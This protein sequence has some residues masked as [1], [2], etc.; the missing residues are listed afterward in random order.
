MGKVATRRS[1][2]IKYSEYE[3]SGEEEDGSPIVKR[4]RKSSVSSDVEK[5]S[6]VGRKK[7]DD[8]RWFDEETKKNNKGM[9]Q[10]KECFVS[11]FKYSVD[12]ITKPQIP[13]SGRKG[14]CKKEVLVATRK[15]PRKLTQ[16]NSIITTSSSGSLEGEE[17][18]K[19][20]VCDGCGEVVPDCSWLTAHIVVCP[21]MN[22][23]L[24]GGEDNDLISQ[25]SIQ[26][27][28]PIEENKKNDVKLEEKFDETSIEAEN[29]FTAQQQQQL[30]EEQLQQQQ[31]QQQQIQ[32]HHIATMN[33][34]EELKSVILGQQINSTNPTI[35]ISNATSVIIQ[36]P[37]P[38]V[39]TPVQFGLEHSHNEASYC[40]FQVNTCVTCG[41]TFYT[42]EALL[43]HVKTSFHQQ[44]NNIKHHLFSCLKCGMNFLSKQSVAFHYKFVCKNENN[45]DEVD[46]PSET[47]LDGG[48]NEM[49][50][51]CWL[52]QKVFISELF[53]AKH[54]LSKHTDDSSILGA[55]QIQ[56]AHKRRQEQLLQQQIQFNKISSDY[57]SL[58]QLTNN[59][60]NISTVDT[61]Q[62]PADFFLQS[63]SNSAIYPSNNISTTL[64][65][66][67]KQLT[68]LTSQFSTDNH[69]Q[70]IYA[71]VQQELSNKET[72]NPLE[73]KTEANSMGTTFENCYTE[74]INKRP[75]KGIM[76][77]NVY[78]Q[79]IVNYHCSQCNTDLS[80]KLMKKEHRRSACFD[81]N[82][83]RSV[84]A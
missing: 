29:S 15:S 23:G 21:G 10:T 33:T 31:L 62:L 52:C 61:A 20:C 47:T 71:N 69:N 19:P 36:N 51:R 57:N 60:N 77:K 24:T 12:M 3:D 80:T 26:S 74:T 64:D 1:S 78:M 72:R 55:L 66:T 2:R 73:E 82:S 54:T 58:F 45:D 38:S 4:L 65:S 35:P 30:Q 48:K 49:E 68:S 34:M 39:C 18:V 75:A 40:E 84:L 42:E 67:S 5:K 16:S 32:Q 25:E 7:K 44:S 11:L 81:G 70:D 14:V 27:S 6:R 9:S 76:Y 28:I 43:N 50:Y 22:G 8:D 37:K 59:N 83:N 79:C 53:L 13:D 41:L 56:L 63:S 46:K 17:G